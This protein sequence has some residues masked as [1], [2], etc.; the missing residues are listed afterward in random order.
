MADASAAGAAAAARLDALVDQALAAAQVGSALQLRVTAPGA[1][2]YA[3]DA[4]FTRHDPVPGAPDPVSGAGAPAPV[5]VPIPR[6]PVVAATRFDLASLTKPLCTTA[7]VMQ[8]VADGRLELDAPPPVPA[9][10]GVTVRHLLAHAAGL[11]AWRPFHLPYVAA[12]EAPPLMARAE[13]LQAVVA[14]PPEAA[15]G[16]RVVYSDLG[17]LL[18]GWAVSHAGG[19]RLDALF[20]ER[21]AAPLGLAGGR[22]GF[23]PARAAA[24]SEEAAR[25]AATELSAWRGRLLAGEVHD[26]TAFV[27]GGV[28][29]HAGLFGDAD[30]VDRVARALCSAWAGVASGPFAP[31]VVREFWRRSPF[32][33][34]PR[35]LGWDMPSLESYSAA[36][37][38]FPRTAVGHTGFT[39]T[40]L[41]VDPA[42]G[43]AVTLLTNRVHPSRHDDRGIRALRA[44]VHDAAIALA[45]AHGLPAGGASGIE[46]R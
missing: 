42:T 21:I 41:W 46:A 4:G 17:F 15:P 37:T 6:A 12:P 28:A 25:F 31:A 10:P 16:A 38:L 34:P 33:P 18:L 3:R 13:V 5:P 32:P 14:E 39:G 36:G 11:S 24:T 26:D 44:A 2:L 27:M 43:L 8:L 30:A 22:L 9:P 40:S 23:R 19:A 1:T 45:L 20:A 35:A 29:G 7:L